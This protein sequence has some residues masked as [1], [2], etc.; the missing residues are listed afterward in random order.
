MIPFLNF[1]DLNMVYKDEILK[2][3]SD[4]I[5]SGRYILGDRVSSFEKDFSEYCGLTQTVGVGNGLD[6]LV[7]ILPAY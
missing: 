1:S 3:V 4:V 6:A 7:L 2:E 5:D